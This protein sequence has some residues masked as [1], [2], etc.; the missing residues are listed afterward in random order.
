MEDGEAMMRAGKAR[1][2][3]KAAPKG[4]GYANGG[5]VGKAAFGNGQSASPAGGVPKMGGGRSGKKGKGC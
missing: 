1:R 4:G 2:N 3:A 5:R